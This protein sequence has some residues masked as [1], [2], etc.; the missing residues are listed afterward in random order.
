M[1]CA[2]SCS[3]T[4]R[5]SIA[6]EAN[7]R[8]N[9]RRS[10]SRT[11]SV[12]PRHRSRIAAPGSQRNPL[13][14]SGTCS[15]TGGGPLHDAPTRRSTARNAAAQ[16]GGTEATRR[17]C[18][19]VSSSA[20]NSSR[21]AASGSA[22]R[23]FETSGSPATAIDVSV[24]RRR[25]CAEATGA[26]A[27]TASKPA[28]NAGKRRISTG[29]DRVIAGLHDLLH[30]PLQVGYDVRVPGRYVGRASSLRARRHRMAEIVMKRGEHVAECWSV[31]LVHL[32]RSHRSNAIRSPLR[33]LTRAVERQR[34]CPANGNH[35]A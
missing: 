12:R 28:R 33:H 6:D 9:A 24:A 26:P 11:P 14:S 22:A 21:A 19:V 10:P 8:T 31:P 29:V 5:S 18:L 20:A 13:P 15:S 23:G 17:A 34:G 4:R 16:P 2:N 30:A 25:A 1:A 35:R 3:H 32:L 27:S 7:S